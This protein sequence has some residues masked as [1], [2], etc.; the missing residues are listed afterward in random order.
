MAHN[1]GSEY[2]VRIVHED[3]TEELSEWIE[4]RR[5]RLRRRWLPATGH[6][7][8][9]TGFCNETF[10]VPT[11]W[12]GNGS[13]WNIPLRI[14]RLHDAAPTTPV[15]CWQWGRGTS[16][17]ELMLSS[18]TDIEL[19]DKPRKAWGGSLVQAV[20]SWFYLRYSTG[21]NTKISTASAH[22]LDLRRTS[23]SIQITKSLS[24]CNCV[25][26]ADLPARRILLRPKSGEVFFSCTD[27]Q[28]VT[29]C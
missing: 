18:G 26:T 29:A 22:L 16:T 17:G 13:S 1:R 25:H 9:L 20:T 23:P 8:K 11:A 28:V 4:Q 5:S 19:P 27:A 7:A 12:I 3:G 2:R 21:A 14:A 6:K 10:F 15:I 24:L